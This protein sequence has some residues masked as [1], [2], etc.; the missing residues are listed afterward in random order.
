MGK[1]FISPYI[2]IT[3]ISD[4]FQF[5]HSVY[6]D[7]VDMGEGYIMLEN[8]SAQIIATGKGI[9]GRVKNW[10]KRSKCFGNIMRRKRILF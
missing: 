9:K 10:R 2:K 3:D 6:F 5:I 4:R 7:Q 1:D 8:K